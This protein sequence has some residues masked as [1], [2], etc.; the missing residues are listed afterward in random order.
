M[1]TRQNF[2]M[3]GVYVQAGEDDIYEQVQSFWSG[4]PYEPNREEGMNAEILILLVDITGKRVINTKRK[5]QR[6]KKKAK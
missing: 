5:P 2:K 1:L 6:E 4:A 3:Q